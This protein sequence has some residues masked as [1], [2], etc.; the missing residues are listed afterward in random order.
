MMRSFSLLA[1]TL[2]C[3]AAQ[4]GQQPSALEILRRLQHLSQEGKLTTHSWFDMEN[5]LLTAE[6]IKKVHSKK[7]AQL[8]EMVGKNLVNNSDPSYVTSDTI[9]TMKVKQQ[10]SK[11]KEGLDHDL[12]RQLQGTAGMTFDAFCS[13]VVVSGN[14]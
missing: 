12:L 5:R 11:V 3:I 9:D 14:L 10:V 8:K 4:S 7:V 13:S 1:A 6:S 2:L